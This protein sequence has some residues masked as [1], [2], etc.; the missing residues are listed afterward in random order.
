MREAHILR[1]DTIKET[2][3]QGMKG[4]TAANPKSLLA[5]FMN[6]MMKVGGP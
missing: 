2:L 5:D 1:E 6:K 3:A 4:I